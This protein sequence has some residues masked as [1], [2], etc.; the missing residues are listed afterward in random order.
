[1]A[2]FQMDSLE[3]GC[4]RL[5]RQGEGEERT[6]PSNNIT[7]FHGMAQGRLPALRALLTGNTPPLAAYIIPS[8]DAHG[9]E[10]IAPAH[11]R[12]EAISGFT[13]SVRLPPPPPPPRGGAG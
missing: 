12:R 4:C 2:V 11:G 9:S 1:M 13:G 8:A 5:S 6:R 3:K 10:Y 7:I